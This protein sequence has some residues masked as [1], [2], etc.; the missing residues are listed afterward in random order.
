MIAGGVY[1]TLPQHRP[2][3]VLHLTRSSLPERGVP[4]RNPDRIGRVYARARPSICQDCTT[5]KQGN[6]IL[7]LENFQQ[8]G[9]IPTG[10]QALGIDPHLGRPLLF[11]QVQGQVAYQRQ[12][13]DRM[14]GPNPALVLS[15]GDIQQPMET[16]LDAPV[17]ANRVGELRRVGRQTAQVG[18]PLH[19]YGLAPPALSL[20]QPDARLACPGPLFIDPTKVGPVVYQPGPAPLQAAMPF[21]E[22]LLVLMGDVGEVRRSCL[23]KELHHVLVEPLLIPLERQ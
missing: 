2:W 12:A 19:G 6:R 18:A 16:I 22:R 4:S 9:V 3:G 15:E 1:V 17:A 21:V 23:L 7:A 13:L 20:N 5:Y 10:F 8:V 14:A 11:K